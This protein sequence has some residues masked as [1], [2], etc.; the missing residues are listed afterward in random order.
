[1]N[2]EIESWKQALVDIYYNNEYYGT[3]NN[4]CEFNLFRIKL[5][6]NKCT[7]LYHAVYKEN[8]ITF[9]QYGDLSEWPLGMYDETMT[10][11]VT[12]FKLRKQLKDKA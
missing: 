6:E 11:Y 8:K 4:E 10:H 2:I 5:V 1:M 7:D 12:L 9:N 3:I